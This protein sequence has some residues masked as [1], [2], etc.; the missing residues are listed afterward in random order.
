ML[1]AVFV[2][3]ALMYAPAV[4]AA[5]GLCTTDSRQVVNELYRHIL[6]RAADAGSAHWVQQLENGR[7]VR[8]VVRDLA[9]SDE[10]MQ[11]FWRQEAGE[12]LPYVRAVG[13]LY[14]HILGRQPDE[15]GARTW[16]Q[17]GSRNGAAV[18]IDR[19]IDSAEYDQQF[20]SWGVPGSGG[21]RYCGPDNQGAAAP[22]TSS[23]LSGRYASMD[24]NKDGVIS[25]NEWQGARLEFDTQDWDDNGVLSDDELDGGAG[26]FGREANDRNT[27]RAQRFETLDVNDNGRIEP[28]EWDG[29]VAA[30]DRLDSNN[31]NVVSRPEMLNVGVAAEPAAVGTSG[32]MIRVNG[33]TRWTDTFIDVRAGDMLLLDADGTVRLSDNGNDV[34]G[35]AGLSRRANDAPFA[36]QAAGALIGRIGTSAPIFIG[37][38]R[39]MRV[40][41]T[42]RLY[43]GVNDDFLDDNSGD[44]QVI[45]TTQR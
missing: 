22:T 33:R 2:A 20:G 7:P 19:L 30:F 11:R 37:N 45:V 36:N 28:R 38:R 39:T 4:A 44:F 18:V 15:A 6:E 3:L 5:Q 16:A 17:T 41:A 8:E 24:R 34:A 12:G 31:D 23:P 14:R 21:V 26:R 10:H 13:T 32:E 42:G 9:K 1:R 40:P 29:T 43:L 35:V 25:L 27:R